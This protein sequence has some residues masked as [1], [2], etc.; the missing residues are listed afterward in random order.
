MHVSQMVMITLLISA[1]ALPAMGADVASGEGTIMLTSDDGK[2]VEGTL[3]PKHTY[4]YATGEG[5]EKKI[6][7]VLTENA[8]PRATWDDAGDRREVVAGWCGDKQGSYALVE[9]KASGK[10]DSMERCGSGGMRSMDGINVMNGLA[11]VVV[12]LEVNDGKRV[13]GTIATGDGACGVNGEP[14]KYCTVTGNYQFDAAL[15][16]PMLADRIWATGD[17]KAPEVAAARKAFESY[18]VAAGKATKISDLTS[19]FTASRAA[20]VAADEASGGAFVG[21]IFK[22]MFLPAHATPVTVVEGRYLSGAALL[23]TTNSVTRRDQTSNQACRTLMRLESG[24]W[25][26]DKES[27]KSS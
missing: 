27:C 23:S 3:K 19:Y 10:A 6:V 24:A 12:K 1:V 8:P 16:P 25:K 13:K 18:W 2:P 21:R 5:A 22:N 17:A 7:L 20:K 4:A 14:P 15:A 11:G 9:L 26:V